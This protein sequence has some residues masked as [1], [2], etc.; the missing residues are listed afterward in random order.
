MVM[1]SVAEA[2]HESECRSNTSSVLNLQWDCS[3]SHHQNPRFSA[4]F[5]EAR[6]GQRRKRTVATPRSHQDQCGTTP[7]QTQQ[8]GPSRINCLCTPSVPSSCEQ[9]PQL[10][11]QPPRIAHPP[12]YEWFYP[13]IY[14]HPTSTRPTYHSLISSTHQVRTHI[15]THSTLHIDT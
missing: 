10:F 5:G 13:P 7:S 9:P 11:L 6:R 3:G 4:L 1:P 12:Y 2:E 15:V 14:H 8:V